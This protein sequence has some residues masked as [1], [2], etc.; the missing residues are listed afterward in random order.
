[1]QLRLDE[2]KYVGDAY[3]LD[4]AWR[5]NRFYVQRYKHEDQ[6]SVRYLKELRDELNG[7]LSEE[8]RDELRRHNLGEILVEHES[9]AEIA[10]YVEPAQQRQWQKALMALKAE[11]TAEALVA[12]VRKEE[13]KREDFA[14]EQIT[15]AERVVRLKNSSIATRNKHLHGRVHF[16]AF[17]I[18]QAYLHNLLDAYAK[19]KQLNESEKQELMAKLLRGKEINYHAVKFGQT[20]SSRAA[21]QAAQQAAKRSQIKTADSAASEARSLQPAINLDR[22]KVDERVREQLS[23]VI[24]LKMLKTI[25][26][27]VE[28]LLDEAIILT[29]A[30]PASSGMLDKDILYNLFGEE[31]KPAQM[32][33]GKNSS[34]TV[35]ILDE[36]GKALALNAEVIALV[37]A[38]FKE[39]VEQFNDYLDRRERDSISFPHFS[40]IAHD[41]KADTEDI[42]EKILVYFE[43]HMDKL[44][45][46]GVVAK[47]MA[48]ALGIRSKLLGRR[49][50]DLKK[51]LPDNHFIHQIASQG[52]AVERKT[53][54]HYRISPAITIEKKILAYFKSNMDVL[55][56]DGVKVKEMAAALIE[57]LGIDIKTTLGRKISNLKKKLLDEHFIH[58][59]E[60]KLVQ[61]KGKQKIYYRFA[62]DVSVEEKILAYFEDNMDKLKGDGIVNTEMA[63]TLSE[64]LGI[65]I[66]IQSLGKRIGSLKKKYEKDT[67]YFI[68]QIES[69]TKMVRGKRATRYRFADDV[70]IEEK[71]LA[72]FEARMEA[73]EGDGIVNTEMAGE[74]TK[75]LGIDIT[76]HSLGYRLSE[77][78]RKYEEK[79]LEH[80]IHQIESKTK[81]VRGK[82]VTR[83]RILPTEDRD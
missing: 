81:M 16:Y 11:T 40:R 34:E 53:V 30:P 12:G 7:K 21:E 2:V 38:R 62:D 75:E 83:Y 58:P 22:G 39:S 65:D 82:K 72:Y 59:I 27:D 18:P 36:E 57:E 63:D 10:A 77:L 37:R 48:A 56:G 67:D 50:S 52:V 15:A 41:S 43:M 74:L 64:E 69:K 29:Y 13:L 49:I 20:D 4:D 78:K 79:D 45:G 32:I 25:G 19:D 73:L 31:I 5:D 42:A 70:S 54:T 24:D 8:L 66:N 51:K 46:D 9:L 60:S 23:D 6:S 28:T 55:K 68:H 80:F 61:V 33:K 3:S 1:M 47:E 26:G 71:I 44:K 35:E 76:S 17:R 14:E